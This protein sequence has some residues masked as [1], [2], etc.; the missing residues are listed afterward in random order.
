MKIKLTSDLWKF[1]RMLEIVCMKVLNLKDGIG[2]SN[3][4]WLYPVLGYKTSKEFGQCNSVTRKESAWSRR[5][6]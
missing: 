3:K 4:F 6:S 5:L 1:P 2:W